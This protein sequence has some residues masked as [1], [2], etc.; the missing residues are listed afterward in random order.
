MGGGNGNGGVVFP[1]VFFSFFFFFF[2]S[3]LSLAEKPH[4][5]AIQR[6]EIK[7][8]QENEIPFSTSGFSEE[9]DSIPVVNPTPTLTPTAPSFNQPSQTPP[10]LTPPTMTQPTPTTTTPTTTTPTA[11]TTTTPTTPSSSGGGSW[12]VASQSAS[13]TAIQVAL[14]YACGYG[15]AD[16]SAI[17]P[18]GS[19]YN[20]NT[21]RDH[22]SYA[23]NDYYSKNPAPTSC[24]FGGA[25]QLTNTDPSSGNCHYASAKS[26]SSMPPPSPMNPSPMIPSP[27]NPSPMVPTTPSMDTPAMDTPPGSSIFGTEP[28]AS[29]NSAISVSYSRTL[30]FITTGL[31][32]ATIAATY[33]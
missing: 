1:L 29:P 18:S 25:A 12:C 20:P 4:L 9:L 23:F 33:H 10:Q 3:G 28:T 24:V 15:G 13:E 2:T 14:D 6:N 32:G 19:C 21:L 30:L 5:K 26:S 16:C 7:E 27:M 8:N 31:F 22:A 17:Q 11:P